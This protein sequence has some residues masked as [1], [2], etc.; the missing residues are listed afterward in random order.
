MLSDLLYRLRALFHRD[1]ME[2]ELDEELRAHIEHRAEKYIQ[3]GMSSEAATR[4]AKLEFGGLDQVKEECRNSWGV[5]LVDELIADVRYGL[6]QLRRNPGFTI[7]AVTTLALGIGANTA[8]FSVLNAVLFQPLPYRSPHQLAMLWTERPSQGLQEDRSAYWNVEQWKQQSKSFSDMAVFDPASVTLA[9]ADKAERIGVARI[10]PNFFSVLGVQPTAGRIFSA[11]E[12][13]QRQR[14]AVISYSFWQSHFGG[15]RNAL[16]ATIELDGVPRQ[17]IGILPA[18]FRFPQLNDDVWEPDTLSPDWD[19]SLAGRG[20]GSWFVVGRL[21]PDVTLKSAQAEMRTIAQRLNRQLP[22]SERNLGISVVPLSLQVAGPGLRLA[23][24]MLTGAVFFVLLIAA[25]NVASLSLARSASREREIAIRT[26]LGATRA[27]IVRQLLAESITLAVLSGLLGLLVALATIRLILVFKPSSLA[28]LNHIG[29][30]LRVLSCALVLCLLTGIL[31]GLA[32]A[33]TMARQSVIRSG[34]EGTRGISGGI[35]TRGIRRA[36]AVTEFALA[37]VLLVGAS[38][39]IR[40]LWSVENIDPGFKAEQVL[41]TQLCTPDSMPAAQRVNFYNRVLEE[42]KSLPGV[43]SAGII[44]NLFVDNTPEQTLTVEG[45]AGTISERLRFRSD[46]VSGGFFKALGTPLLRGRFFSAEDGPDAPRVAIINDAMARR[47]WP[48]R[49]PLGEK[50]KLGPGDSDGVEFTVVGVVGNMHRSGLESEPIPQM[51][52]P[53]AQDPSRLATLL[54]RTSRG[55]PLSMV[56]M[57]QSAVHQIDKQVPVYDAAT[58]EHRLGAFLGQR[59]FQTS[60]LIGFS[61]VALLM[62]AIG[63]FGLIQYFVATRTHEIGIRMA[64]GAQKSDVLRMIVGQGLR[65]ALAGVGLGLAGAIVVSR[66]LS[67]LLYGVK[68]TDPLTF[69]AVTLILTAVALLAC[70]IP[71]R[72]AAKVDP[73][74]ALRYE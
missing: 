20:A 30:D 1:S 36:L 73:M 74:E 9:G 55:N 24:W 28:H 21:R 68:P 57:L 5:R 64:L 25:T 18:D 2:A 37:T 43:E 16:G 33:I 48:G 70:Y 32:P 23:L 39:L 62:A 45:G 7:V 29:L 17:I 26:A 11:R 71:A 51:F 35:A 69:V 41:S 52:E 6:R 56:G 13:E 31:T 15:S 66:F 46:E 44:E 67:S 53:L 8:M 42:I 40:S 34:Q 22:A 65:L 4:Q 3:S 60:L 58:L 50:L 47:L 14:L 10:S 27:R 59:R 12:A 72:R 63:I 54:V 49:D 61:A 38:L 19:A